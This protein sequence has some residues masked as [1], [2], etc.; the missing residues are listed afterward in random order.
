MPDILH[1]VGVKSP[2]PNATYQALATVDGLAAWWT[3]D[4]RGVSAVDGE[5]EFHFGGPDRFFKMAALELSP[6]KR[7]LWEVIDGPMEWLGTQVSFDLRQE[8]DYTIVLFKHTGW[9]APV[10]FMHHCSTKWA[11][12]LMS[13]KSLVETG[14]GAPHPNDVRIDNW[15]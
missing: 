12:F 14:V 3:H 9:K 8:D 5:L 4:T 6:Q 7:I 1:K 10:E 11:T 2:S 13:L 15:K